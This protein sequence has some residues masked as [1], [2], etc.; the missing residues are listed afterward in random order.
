MSSICRAKIKIVSEL[1][2]CGARQELK[3]HFWESDGESGEP[4][5]NDGESGEAEWC[6]IFRNQFL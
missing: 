2:L 5:E 3:K 4:V 6:K 1:R